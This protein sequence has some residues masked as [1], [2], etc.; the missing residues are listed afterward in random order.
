MDKMYSM[1]HREQGAGCFP[2]LGNAEK[3]LLNMSCECGIC[4][5]IVYSTSYKDRI[6]Y[7]RARCLLIDD[8]MI[9]EQAAEITLERIH[10]AC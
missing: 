9:A 5:T 3:N 4:K 2:R 7:M 8:Y 1:N 10:T 6:V